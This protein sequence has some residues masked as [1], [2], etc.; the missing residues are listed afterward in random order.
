MECSD[1]TPPSVTFLGPNNNDDIKTWKLTPCRPPTP[2]EIANKQSAPGCLKVMGNAVAEPKDG[3]VI[4]DIKFWLINAHQGTFFYR[5]NTDVPV[6]LQY[7]GRD[8]TSWW[9]DWDVGT[10]D[11]DN[12]TFDWGEGNWTIMVSVHQRYTNIPFEDEGLWSK[13]N[14]V[15]VTVDHPN[16]PIPPEKF[17]KVFAGHPGTYTIKSGHSGVNVTFKN[18]YVNVTA[19]AK[20]IRIEWAFENQSVI[21]WAYVPTNCTSGTTCT[22]PETSHI[23]THEGSYTAYLCAVDQYGRRVCDSKKVYVMRSEEPT[24]LGVPRPMLIAIT[25]IIVVMS[26]IIITI[27]VVASLSEATKFSIMSFILVPLYSRLKKEEML[28]NYTRGEIRG[29]IVANP[30]AH[31]SRIKRD[32]DLNN[33][34]LIYHLTT[35][36]REGFIYSHRD[37]YYR[38]FYPR[39]RKPRPGPNLTTVQETIIEM[40][41]ENPGLSSEEVAVRLNKSRK[42]V[43]YHLVWLR[44]WGQ[45][46]AKDDGRRKTYS[47]IFEDE[48]EMK[49][50]GVHAKVGQTETTDGEP[51]ELDDAKGRGPSGPVK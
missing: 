32:L 12:E 3:A 49:Q 48:T 31:Y 23:F 4:D 29:Y 28:D 47:V 24:V 33:G 36:E 27:L 46:E 40:L 37:D 15:I 30:G 50:D 7:I 9:F 16:P 1:C 18:A 21:D 34:T 51:D 20:I 38:R 41:L 10:F 39:G 6:N 14:S 13:T 35:L 2:T 5:M 8:E 42:V 22:V 26:T 44:R 25:A 45:V 43:N 19:N 17:P 11:I